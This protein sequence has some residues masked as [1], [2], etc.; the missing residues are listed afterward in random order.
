MPSTQESLP[1]ELKFT[2]EK[3]QG[4]MPAREL[5]EVLDGFD[6]FAHALSAASGADEIDVKVHALKEASF[7]IALLLD[8]AGNAGLGVI[9]WSIVTAWWKVAFRRVTNAK[10]DAQ[11]GMVGITFT[12]GGY[13]EVP[14]AA[15]RLLN[16]R[17]AKRAMRK[18]TGP[19][20]RGA[21]KLVITGLEAEPRT[22]LPSEAVGM[23]DDPEPV[24]PTVFTTAATVDTLRFKS[25]KYWRLDTDMGTI[26][27]TIEDEAFLTSLKRGTRVGENDVFTVRMRAE[28]DPDRGHT[29]YFVEKVMNHVPGPEQEILPDAD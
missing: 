16:D 15:W 22:I 27:A 21:D 10:H 14:E 17:E 23:D 11:T 28:T 25:A 29:K 8:V 26:G 18:I 2:G 6:K 13:A 9:L 19:L 7:D 24:V 5:S 12:D 20:R 3:Y 4:V 1:V